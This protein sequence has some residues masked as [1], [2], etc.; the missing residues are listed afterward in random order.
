M[1]AVK[2]NT[3]ADKLME[4]KVKRNQNLLPEIFFSA[5]ISLLIFFLFWLLVEN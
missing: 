5:G 3:T 1:N 2:Y 4:F